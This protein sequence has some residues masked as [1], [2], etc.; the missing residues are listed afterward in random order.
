MPS[1]EQERQK[2]VEEGNAGALSIKSTES[3][4]ESEVGFSPLHPSQQVLQS[5]YADLLERSVMIIH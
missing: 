5:T 4:V 3:G 1:Q 2:S